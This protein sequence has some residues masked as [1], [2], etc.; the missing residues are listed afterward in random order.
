MSKEFMSV[1]EIEKVIDDYGTSKLQT[2]AVRM[3]IANQVHSLCLKAHEAIVKELKE[4]L[5]DVHTVLGS[6]NEFGQLIDP[7]RN[8]HELAQRVFNLIDEKDV[9]T[10]D[11]EDKCKLKDEEIAELKSICKDLSEELK[12]L[13]EQ[14]KDAL[15]GE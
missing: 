6:R 14:L 11:L 3:L 4:E 7:E 12:D 1:E 8:L 10:K 15:G 5:T 13:R 2:R 9:E